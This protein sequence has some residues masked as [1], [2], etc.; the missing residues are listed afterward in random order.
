MYHDAHE[1]RITLT[2]EDS[3]PDVF[4]SDNEVDSEPEL[5]GNNKLGD[6]YHSNKS[7]RLKCW[8]HHQR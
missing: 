5:E 3:L 7:W 4:D 2:V 8:W 6:G 1:T